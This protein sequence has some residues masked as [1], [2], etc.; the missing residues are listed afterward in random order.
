MQKN[1][2][3]LAGWLMKCHCDDDKLLLDEINFFLFFAGGWQFTLIT[4]L[5]TP[6]K[7]LTT[8]L[9][10]FKI[11]FKLSLKHIQ[12]IF[13]TY[14][15]YSLSLGQWA[16]TRQLKS[17]S[18]QSKQMIS[19]QN[20][21]KKKNLFSCFCAQTPGARFANLQTLLSLLQTGTF[22]MNNSTRS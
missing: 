20:Q 8:H 10:H 21:M 14:L 15:M 12:N 11:T 6:G 17:I 3:R 4:V 9:K 5:F 22:P 2:L 1:D 7:I 13:N 18:R 16:K 19:N